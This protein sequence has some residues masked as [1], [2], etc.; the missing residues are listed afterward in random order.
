MYF[1][2]KEEFACILQ[3]RNDLRCIWLITDYLEEACS[4]S[5]A[6]CCGALSLKVQLFAEP[7]FQGRSQVFEKDTSQIDDSFPVKSSKVLSGR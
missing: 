4:K 5:T 3:Y 2:F 1:T 6:K 7:E